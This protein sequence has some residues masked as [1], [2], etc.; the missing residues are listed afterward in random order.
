M[1]KIVALTLDLLN[2]N[3]EWIDRYNDYPK[4]IW[5]NRKKNTK[6]FRKPEGLSFYTTLGDRNKKRYYLRFKGQNIGELSI[7]KHGNKTLKCLV[8]QDGKSHDIKNCPLEK[9]EKCEWNSKEASK[10]RGYFKNLAYETKTKSPEHELE[11]ALLTEFKKS[12]K[13]TK[14]IYNI[15]PVRLQGG[16]FQMPT[17]ISASSGE[18]K[19]AKEKGGGI[20]ILARFTNS[21]GKIRLCVMEV[22]DENLPKESQKKAMAQAISYATFIS[23]LLSDQPDWWEIFSE[24]ETKRGRTV[25]NLDRNNIEVVTI[26]PEGNTEEFCNETV[27]IPE[28]DMTLHCH[29]L[30]YKPELFKTERKFKFE[31]TFL[32]ELKQ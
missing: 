25:H 16:Y 20:D 2:S 9:D 5:D 18:I 3:S 27:L 13:G 29:S 23:K 28:T 19:Y 21:S 32:N 4:T 30:Y 26:M 15:Q 11:N 14:S 24:H 6:G 7:D 10:F 8:V 17:P 22:K 12:A 1:E 31:G